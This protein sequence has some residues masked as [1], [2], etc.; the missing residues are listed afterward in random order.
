MSEFMTNEFV[1]NL[2]DE[3]IYLGNCSAL[4]IFHEK[5]FYMIHFLNNKKIPYASEFMSWKTA[6]GKNTKFVFIGLEKHMRSLILFVINKNL[7]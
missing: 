2:F 3:K 1:L 5:L 4:K 7:C 6:N